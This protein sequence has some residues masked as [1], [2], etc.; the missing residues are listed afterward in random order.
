MSLVL[1]DSHDDVCQITLN[2]P[3]RLNA[4]NLDLL[5]ELKEVIAKIDADESARAVIVTGAGR[6]FSAGADLES[7]FGEIDRPTDE[8]RD[9]LLGV[10]A[11]FLGLRTL[12]I[13]TIAAV[14]GPAVGAGLNIAL[15]CDVIIAGPK[16]KFGPTFAEI[17]LHPG[18]GCSWML[19][20]RL[21]QS[22]ATAALLSGALIDAG[23]A[24]RIGLCDEKVDDAVARAHEL[25]SLY[26][27]REPSLNRAIKESVRLAAA[28]DFDASLE[29]ESRRQ[30]ESVANERFRAHLASFTSRGA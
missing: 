2:A 6:G 4:L 10:Y 20:E 8:M 12:S 17:G 29:H 30:A 1:L 7:M 13:P 24:W 15:A 3:E 16:A 11:S 22:R 5:A 23:D 14:N 9:H 25:A 26:A 21:G 27:A 19:T 18:G 28:S